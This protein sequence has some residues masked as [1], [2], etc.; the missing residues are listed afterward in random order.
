M[1]TQV[2]GKENVQIRT[3]SQLLRQA[4][5]EAVLHFF[6]LSRV[7]TSFDDSEMWTYFCGKPIRLT[8]KPVYSTQKE[9]IISLLSAL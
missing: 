3:R 2:T 4:L 7:P 1:S 6:F 9:R 8:T 5:S